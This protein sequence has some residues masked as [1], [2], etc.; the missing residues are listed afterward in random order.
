MEFRILGAVGVGDGTSPAAVPAAK[1]R[2]LLAIL[3]LNA[4][5]P[6]ATDRLIDQL[7]D[8]RPPASAR[9]VLQ[10]YVSKLRR[11]IGDAA[12]LTCPTGYELVVRPGQLDLHRFEGFVAGA[13]D[14]A[15]QE[16]AELL[17]RALAEWRGPPLADVRHEA[18]AQVEVAR[19]EELRV[20]AL[21]DR[22]DADLALG[23]HAELVA[24]L[25]ALVAEH[26]LRE[27]LR[28]RLM[29]AL[30]RSGR[31]IEA[32]NVHREG[33]QQLVEELGVE[34]G[35]V[36]QELEAAILR[37]DPALGVPPRAEA[38]ARH[39]GADPAA[40]GSE[41]TRS[42]GR[43]GGE[44]RVPATSFIGRGHELNVVQALLTS[45]DVRLVTLAG[46]GGAGKTRLAIEA[47]AR[48]RARFADGVVFVD[49]SALREP[50]LVMSAVAEAIG[51]R[52]LS[53]ERAVEDVA[54][55]LCSR[56]VL[57]VLDNFE[58]V[59]GAAPGLGRLLDAAS[60]LT[61]LVTSRARLCAPDEYVFAVPPL[62]LP[63]VGAAA[64]TLRTF[65]AVALFVE[66]G[67]AA[68]PGFTIAEGNA[69][70]VVELCRRL[71]GL[72]LALELAAAR[73]S[74]LSPR[75]ILDRFDRRFDLLRC[76]GS[77]V[78]ER[79]RTLRAALEW[80]HDLLAPPVQALFTAL[81]VFVGGFTADAAEQ[82]AADGEDDVL[83]G[84]SSLLDV[85]L[86]RPLGVA[87]DEPRFGMLETIREYAL[88]RAAYSGCRTEL[89]DR[90]ARWCLAL[91]EEAEPALRGP[92]QVRWLARLDAEHDNMRAAL[93]WA[94]DGG[95]LDVGLRTGAALWRFW[96]VRGHIEDGRT[97]LE[98]LLDTGPGSPAARAAA[99]LTVARCAFIQG[100]YGALQRY[101]DACIP[102][103]RDL[104]DDH[105]QGFALMIL[106]A[107]T[108]TR[109]DVVR[110]VA[111][112]H[113]AVALS[114]TSGN[115][116]L[117]A[118]CLGYLGIV[119]ARGGGIATA[120]RALEEGLTTARSLGD[121]RCVG[122]M[123]ITLGR[124]A[125]AAADP[126]HARARVAEA[127]V[128]QQRL[129]DRWGVSS[130]LRESVAL[131]LDGGHADA[132]TASALLAESLS[133]A[134]SAHDRPSVAAGLDLSARL[135]ARTD[136]ARAAQLLGCASRLERALNDPLAGAA[137]SEDWVTALHRT[138]GDRAFADAWARGRAMSL[139]EAVA[140]ALGP[141][142]DALSRVIGAPGATRPGRL[143]Q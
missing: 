50:A 44:L 11:V 67:E 42:L 139:H 131:A 15:P 2:A 31:Q 120:R 28:A 47:S 116:W 22:I 64:S 88:D 111:L 135:R 142:D 124:I 62:P 94:A 133:L 71:D 5:Q 53:P 79:H 25:R 122:W 78:T 77:P 121:H 20:A 32:L 29:L 49:L 6:V 115:R 14:A 18:F 4:N 136:P 58:Q 51:L 104:G 36:L 102:V 123:L 113:E 39:P 52:E 92:D 48:A 90:H 80:S 114:R 126:E 130:A 140:F 40:P 72:P 3:L 101:T 128:V 16:A 10:T 45:H 46:P 141:A 109:G 119:L 129:G 74:L 41:S 8:G 100:D 12:L 68:Q 118:S 106:G 103:H 98:R 93:E 86:L 9:K 55:Y 1:Q 143:L 21:E 85:S 89:R 37:Q 84:L 110:G 132:G 73:L 117:E 95:A 63:T 23:R 43:R 57:L 96:Q 87:G 91:A 59:I 26:P 13:R 33:R 83:D 108:G 56:Q 30:Y 38:G 54:E 61:I 125:R 70:D 107:A 7:W 82:L 60:G 27:Q 134:L 97:R 127:L 99:Q 24:E 34:P 137:G 75:G 81:G 69:H 19:L 138:L 105:S 76:T 66:R 35:S 65:D 112:L 17:R